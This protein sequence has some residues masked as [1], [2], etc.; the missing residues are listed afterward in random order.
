M[1]PASFTLDASET[2]GTLFL[3]QNNDKV[4]WLRADIFPPVGTTVLFP[5]ATRATVTDLTL[6]LNAS[7]IAQIFVGVTKA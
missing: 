2:G 7:G 3:D 1:G 6:D 5:D 4:A